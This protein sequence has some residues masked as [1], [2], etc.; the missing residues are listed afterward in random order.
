MG[1]DLVSAGGAGAAN[2]ELVTQRL[3]GTKSYEGSR[4]GRQTKLGKIPAPKSTYLTAKI[5]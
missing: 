2:L 5:F 4:E 1:L 3:F